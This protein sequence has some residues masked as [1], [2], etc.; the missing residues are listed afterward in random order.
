MGNRRK[1]IK[2]GFTI[3]RLFGTRRNRRL[4][5]RSEAPV[6]PRDWHALGSSL[7]SL[8]LFA[9][10]VTAVVL[11][12]LCAGAGGYLAYDRVK[13]SS[14][15]MVQKVTVQGA[16]RARPA[17]LQRLAAMVTG[18]HIFSVDLAAARRAVETHAWVK[19]ARVYRDYPNTVAVVVTEHQPKALLLIGHLYLVSS[20]GK[21][22]KK[23][24]PEEAHRLPVITGISRLDHINKP[25]V[26]RPRLRRALGALDRYRS[27]HRPPLSEVNI[28]Q[29]GDITLF[30]RRNGVALRFGDE[31]SLQRLT[32]LD[33][34][35]A[36]LGPETRR[37]RVVF[38]DNEVRTDRVTVRMGSY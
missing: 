32:R 15:F 3:R 38:L 31:V 12:L 27:M 34:V 24:S 6:E 28:G 11:V 35:W 5:S 7:L 33:A 21:I 13:G 4:E 25:Q 23:A 26:T 22:F 36:A 20:D 19:S 10:R 14:T 2:R 16:R 8:G 30:L 1:T 17:D 9:A 29:R 37:V 18:R